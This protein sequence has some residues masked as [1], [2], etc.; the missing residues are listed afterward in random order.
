MVGGHVL[1]RAGD[2][3]LVRDDIAARLVEVG[4][5][6][7]ARDP[8]MPRLEDRLRHAIEIVGASSNEHRTHEDTTPAHCFHDPT[9]E[10]DDVGTP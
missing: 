2:T 7:R 4:E 9:V 8:A 6:E 10:Q 3:G 1:P 5:R